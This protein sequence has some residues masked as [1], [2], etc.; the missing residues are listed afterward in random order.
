MSWPFVLSGFS[1]DVLL[2]LVEL[3]TKNGELGRY[4]R[5]RSSY[6]ICGT[7]YVTLATSL[8]VCQIGCDCDKWNISVAIC[9]TRYSVTLTKSHI[10]P[11]LNLNFLS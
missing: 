7:C 4:G 11:T 6:S 1:Q 9:D 5:V 8:V 10:I 3:M 2:I